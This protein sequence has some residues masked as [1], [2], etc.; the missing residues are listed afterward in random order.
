LASAVLVGEALRYVATEGERW[1]ALLGWSTA[2]FKCG[3]RDAWIGWPERLQWPRLRLIASNARFVVLPQARQPHL[4]S[5]VLGLSCR[6]LSRD[7]QAAFGHPVF[8]AETFVDSERFLGTC[9]RAAGWTLL[10]ETKGF[11]RSAG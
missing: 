8:L 10:G 6:R 11:G 3:P 5:R 7:W 1:L 4:A 9:Y 2:A